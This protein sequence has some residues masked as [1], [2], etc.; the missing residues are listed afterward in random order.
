[1]PVHSEMTGGGLFGLRAGYWTDDTSMALCLA[2]SLIA[3]SSFDGHD[4]MIRFKGWWRKG[5]NSP[6]GEC[7]DIGNATAD[8]LERF[9]ID[10]TFASDREAGSRSSGNGS[11]M[12][13]APAAIYAFPEIKEAS[14]LAVCQSRVTHATHETDGAC[15]FFAKLLVQAISGIPK[16]QL[17]KS[18]DGEFRY[19]ELFSISRGDWKTKTRDQIRSSGYVLHTLEAALWSVWNSNSFEEALILA[20]NLGDDADSVGAVTGQLAGAI[21]GK[22][23][24]PNRWLDQLAWK[25]IIEARAE[26]LFTMNMPPALQRNF[27]RV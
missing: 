2:D 18:E 19:P 17:L 11:L 27:K 9:E 7:F 23:A 25:D 14:K 16:D 5:E 22:S 21:W 10:G 24:I 1:M 4:L 3:C 20:V 26:A 13:L 12:R 6:T 8:A 15:A